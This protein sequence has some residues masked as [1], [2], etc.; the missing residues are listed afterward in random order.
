MRDSFFNEYFLMLTFKSICHQF[1]GLC[2][3][4]HFI[5]IFIARH[6]VTS[7]TCPDVTTWSNENIRRQTH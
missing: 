1:L 3:L 7:T 4:T 6:N 2:L 5:S